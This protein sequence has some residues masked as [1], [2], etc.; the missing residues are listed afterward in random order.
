MN[1]IS[2][3]GISSIL[4]CITLSGCANKAPSFIDGDFGV[5]LNQPAGDLTVTGYNDDYTLMTIKPS[6]P[7]SLFKDVSKL[8]ETPSDFLQSV[9]FR[10][11]LIE[12]LYNS[13]RSIIKF[14]NKNE[15]AKKISINRCNLFGLD[16]NSLGLFKYQQTFHNYFSLSR[17]NFE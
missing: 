17:E 16:N 5:K 13:M 1:K 12:N 11:G 14:S 2:I 7:S 15:K 3:L 6:Q 10:V 9:E 8:I 4:A